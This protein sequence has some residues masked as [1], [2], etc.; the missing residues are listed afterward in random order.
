MTD[1]QITDEPK[2]LTV[3]NKT[4]QII[5]N[6]YKGLTIQ[7]LVWKDL[8]DDPLLG[9]LDHGYYDDI[10]L[11]SDYY[12]G[13]AIIE[14]PGEHK[15]TDLG[16]VSP[17]I[18]RTYKKIAVKTEQKWNHCTFSSSIIL[19][20]ER[21]VLNKTITLDTDEKAIIRPYNFTLNPQAWDRYSL[22]VGTHNGGTNL[23]RFYL[24]EKK[25]SHGD[26]YSSLISARHGFGNTEGL[27]VIGDKDKSIS[28]EC[29][30]S[31][32]ALIPSIMFLDQDGDKYFF[33]LQY[34]ASEIDE[35]V[36]DCEF[37]PKIIKCN[38]EIKEGNLV[39]L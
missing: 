12:S 36:K 26:I 24:R 30:M 35:T 31:V 9:T 11:G 2:W 10:S 28:F 8:S 20:S 4:Y 27:F 16:S 1:S 21:I 18:V 6:K 29:D 38:L 23:E 39:S 34:S 32:A 17:E 5:F 14:R 3:K 13:H 25:I 19:Q 37:S 22:Y 7:Q 33:R 15:V